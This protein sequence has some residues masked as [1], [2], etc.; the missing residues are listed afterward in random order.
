MELTPY[1][2]DTNQISSRSAKTKGADKI[3]VRI[4]QNSWLARI[5][6]RCIRERDVALT[7]FSTIYLSH[8][9]P[10]S[11]LRNQ[12]WV[13]H[14][15]AHVRQF[16][17]YGN[18]KFIFMYLTESLRKGYYHNKWEIEARAQEEKVEIL[19]EFYFEYMW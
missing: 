1:T 9:S 18:L 5:A 4:R 10:A 15:L 17:T 7:V 19:Q 6:C 16:K 3:R 12:S 14:E 13:A 11:F 2:Q 8:S